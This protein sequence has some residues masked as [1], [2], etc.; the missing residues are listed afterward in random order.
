M[1]SLFRE[2]LEVRNL[3]IL[4]YFFKKFLGNQLITI[5]GKYMRI[6]RTNPYAMVP[7]DE[8]SEEWEQKTKLECMFSF[9]LLSSPVSVAQANIPSKL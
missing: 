4:S 9:R 6:F 2:Q 3:L 7:L 5:G 8:D 1:E